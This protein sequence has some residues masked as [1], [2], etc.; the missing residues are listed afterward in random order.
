[1]EVLRALRMA[2]GACVLL[3]LGHGRRQVAPMGV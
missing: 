3:R 1:M 2:G